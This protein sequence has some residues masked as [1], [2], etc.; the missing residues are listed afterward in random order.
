ML[1]PKKSMAE[2]SVE[3][4]TLHTQQTNALTVKQEEYDRILER[5]QVV[6][7]QMNALSW[8]EDCRRCERSCCSHQGLLSSLG[9][10]M[11]ACTPVVPDELVE[12]E[13]TQPSMDVDRV[14]DRNNK[15]RLG[16]PQNQEELQNLV[17]GVSNNMFWQT[18]G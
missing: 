1:E 11:C 5:A 8:K 7:E 2:L 12:F 3:K 16:T 6:S 18:F 10:R 15:M 17:S 14:E 13:A 9:L 4:E